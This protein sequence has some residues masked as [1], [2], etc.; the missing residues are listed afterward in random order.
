M[1]NDITRYVV[2]VSFHEQALTELNELTNHLTRAGFTLT[3]T[4][5]DGKLHE[6][7]TNTFGLVSPLSH[8]DV[9][10][11]TAGLAQS[12]LGREAEVSVATFEHWLAENAAP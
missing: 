2:T 4:D 6:L 1:S 12:A 7:G 9:I 10:A 11:L 8:D 5:D 3:L